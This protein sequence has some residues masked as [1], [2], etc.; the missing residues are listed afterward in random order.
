MH[1]YYHSSGKTDLDAIRKDAHYRV[2][3]AIWPEESLIHLHPKHEPRSPSNNFELVEVECA[4][5][6]KDR[7]SELPDH[8]WVL[9][10]ERLE[11]SK[12]ILSDEV[13]VDPNSKI[14][15]W[16]DPNDK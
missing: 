13:F 11:A 5:G 7:S 9:F 10:A 2:M 8:E 1:I 3:D 4:V 15:T 12:P 6:P 14:L 16:K